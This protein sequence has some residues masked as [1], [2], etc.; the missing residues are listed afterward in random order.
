MVVYLGSRQRNSNA[1][2]SNMKPVPELPG[3]HDILI[4]Q[5]V[6]IYGSREK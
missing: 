1:R 4:L 2:S 3:H 5:T 6:N